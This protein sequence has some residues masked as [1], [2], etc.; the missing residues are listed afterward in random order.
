MTTGVDAQTCKL[1]AL[2]QNIRYKPPK[3]TSK[4]F[5]QVDREFV[6]MVICW[7]SQ[8]IHF[9]KPLLHI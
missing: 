9:V 8:A 1:I 3:T 2:D 4:R 5:L 7:C 6:I